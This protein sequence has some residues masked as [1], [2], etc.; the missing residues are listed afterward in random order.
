[1]TDIDGEIL[2]WIKFSKGDITGHAFHGNQ[3]TSNESLNNH[4]GT[5]NALSHVTQGLAERGASGEKGFKMAFDHDLV[6]SGHEQI[7]KNIAESNATGKFPSSW[8]GAQAAIDAHE[9][10]ARANAYA[11]DAHMATSS[12]NPEKDLIAQQATVDAQKATD[13]AT[14]LTKNI[15]WSE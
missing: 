6:R 3:Y 1:M 12:N 8:H 11:H 9:A 14:Y 2:S 13:R 10:A 5:S 4:I 15:P 7:A